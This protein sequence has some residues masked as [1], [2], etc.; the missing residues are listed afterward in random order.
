MNRC[1]VAGARC[2]VIRN[3]DQVTGNWKV[4]CAVKTGSRAHSPRRPTGG[5][6]FETATRVPAES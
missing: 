6:R 5:D 1:Q 4:L 3:S 2:Q